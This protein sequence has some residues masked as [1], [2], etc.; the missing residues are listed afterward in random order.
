MQWCHCPEIQVTNSI[1][2]PTPDPGARLSN[3][4]RVCEAGRLRVKRTRDVSEANFRLDQRRTDKRDCTWYGEA[5]CHGDEVIVSIS[6]LSTNSTALLTTLCQD[7][8]RWW[9]RMV[10]TNGR[11][12]MKPTQWRDV[13]TDPR[14]QLTRG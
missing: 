9:F 5:F 14:F 7:L 4:V 10:C 3:Y 2:T 6:Y 8:H 1:L 11:M 13:V 12:R